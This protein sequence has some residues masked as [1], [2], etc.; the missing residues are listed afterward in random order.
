MK[1]GL[2]WDDQLQ[3]EYLNCTGYNTILHGGLC[4]SSHFADLTTKVQ[5]LSPWQAGIAF[6]FKSQEAFSSGA[7]SKHF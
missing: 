4:F 2:H 1:M 3:Y 6:V 7:K 5:K